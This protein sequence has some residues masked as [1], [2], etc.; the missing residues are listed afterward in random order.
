MICPKI[1]SFSVDLFLVWNRFVSWLFYFV[2]SCYNA[3]KKNVT[4]IEEQ[5]V[6]DAREW[7]QWRIMRIKSTFHTRV[8][9]ESL[10]NERSLVTSFSILWLLLEWFRI[11]SNGQRNKKKDRYKNSNKKYRFFS[12]LLF[13]HW[14]NGKLT[15]TYTPERTKDSG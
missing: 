11:G 1:N 14:Q 7:N 15:S 3:R 10:S 12:F 9:W 5:I 2:S 4:N 13:F 8:T 6:A